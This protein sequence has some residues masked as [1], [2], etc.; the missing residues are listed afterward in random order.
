[1]IVSAVIAEEI[2]WSGTG[3]VTSVSGSGFSGL[4]VRAD[5]PVGIRFS[6]DPWATPDVPTYIP[7]LGYRETVYGGSVALLVTVEIGGLTWTGSLGEAPE[8]VYPL[9]LIDYSK[10]AAE[11]RFS[12]L[13]SSV[14]GGIF[15]SFPAGG[16]VGTLRELS[17]KFVDA[18]APPGFLVSPEFLSPTALPT[19]E[20]NTC[21]ITNAIGIIKA[22]SETIGFSIDPFSLVIGPPPSTGA[23]VPVV[24]VRAGTTMELRWETRA[25]KRYELQRSCHLR[26]WMMVSVHDG[27]GTSLAIPQPPSGEGLERQFYRVVELD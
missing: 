20:T 7:I 5:D 4:G 12:V 15:S 1:M 14:D 10:V 17:L 27:T 26:S 24:I 18:V 19:E 8:G 23:P 11:D 2:P 21:E 9:K 13:L 22:G 6:Y 25:G 3:V 16:E